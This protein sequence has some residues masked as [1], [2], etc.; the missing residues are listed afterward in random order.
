MI[1]WTFILGSSFCFVS[2]MI[3]RKV[4]AIRYGAAC[5][6]KVQCPQYYCP[7]SDAYG[8]AG[9]LDSICL[10]SSIKDLLQ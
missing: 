5:Y 7:S 10:M 2:A 8:H 4:I 3:T 6:S 1:L 9:F